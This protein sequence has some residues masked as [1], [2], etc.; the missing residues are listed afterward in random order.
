MPLGPK[1]EGQNF[2]SEPSSR[3]DSENPYGD[4]IG[5]YEQREHVVREKA[6]HVAQAQKLREQVSDCYRKEGVNHLQ[7]CRELVAKYMDSIKGV[8]VQKINI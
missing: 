7:N 2:S 8:G 6:V 4:A 1:Y 5:F 3:F